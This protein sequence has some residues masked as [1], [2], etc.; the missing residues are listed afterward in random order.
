MVSATQYVTY[1]LCADQARYRALGWYGSDSRQSLRGV[2]AHRVFFRHLTGDGERLGPEDV[3]TACL[4]EIG[5]R[6]NSRL[7]GLGLAKMSALRPLLAEVGDLYERFAQVSTAGLRQAELDLV[8]EPGGAVTL[9]GTVDAV[10]EDESGVRLVDWKTGGLGDSQHQ[11]D[12]Y[13]LL[14][15]LEH[16]EMPASVEASSVATGDRYVERPTTAR[17]EDVVSRVVEL[18]T[19]LREAYRT[20]ESL[21]RRGGP[22]CRWCPALGE[23]PEGASVIRIGA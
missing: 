8:H 10:F 19:C 16:G 1:R 14:W 9:R 4:E 20:G 23:C 6:F 11:L 18:V 21:P 17:L 13:A 15:T 12:F 2:L 5:E 3:V 7:P 22:H